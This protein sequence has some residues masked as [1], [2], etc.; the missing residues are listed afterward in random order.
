MSSTSEAGRRG[1]NQ[2]VADLLAEMAQLLQA[3]QST[4]FRAAAYRTAAEKVRHLEHS[5]REIFAS[6]GL[7][8][9]DRI[10]A[11]GKGIAAAI[12]E[13]LATGRWSQLDRLRGSSEPEA[14]LQTVPGI[15]PDLA[16]RI[17]DELHIDSLQ[18]LEAAAHDGRLAQLRGI[19]ER[20]AQALRAAV[21][22]MLDRVR[23]AS[24]ASV[25]RE[26]RAAPSVAEI[27]AV[28]R[29]Y[30]DKAA[31]GELRTIAPRRFNPAGE[32]WLPVWH[33]HRG[34]WH[35]TALYSNT[36]R[37]HEL[38]KTRDWVVIYYDTEGQAEGQN[39]VVT[40]TH[41]ALAGYRVVRGRERECRTHYLGDD[42][43]PQNATDANTH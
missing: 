26:P 36:A 23:P 30:R 24:A 8:G 1:D 10:P 37:A 16:H 12:A 3:Q 9:L 38:G 5:V 7:A 6:E 25:L 34:I 35:F 14:L 39:T 42:N 43:L 29:Q 40:E 22:N 27:L 32:A 18:A 11:V 17:H 20:R 4:P 2:A 15:G 19:G 21:T 31:R 41:G 13:I 33:A 28:D